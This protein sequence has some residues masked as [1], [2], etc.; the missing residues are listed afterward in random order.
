M[1]VE[2]EEV[3]LGNY[4]AL[5]GGVIQIGESHYTRLPDLCQQLQPLR[6]LTK[7]LYTL[8]FSPVRGGDWNNWYRSSHNG[9]AVHLKAG[10]GNQW[11]VQLPG[12]D[13]VRLI[14]YIH[15]LQNLWYWLFEEPLRKRGGD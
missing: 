9:I 4:F 11:I 15:Q 14:R 6:L 8:G 3:Q 7:R 1:S 13:K 10:P 12:Q 2:L 5:G